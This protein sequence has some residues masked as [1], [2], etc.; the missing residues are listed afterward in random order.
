VSTTAISL[1][2]NVTL[3][4]GNDDYFIEQFDIE[5]HDEKSAK[6]L[7]RQIAGE[8]V[9]GRLH[10]AYVDFWDGR[11]LVQGFHFDRDELQWCPTCAQPGMKPS[12]KGSPRCES[13]SIASGG[14][15][16]HCTCDVCF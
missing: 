8:D 5:S 1:K 3:C 15:N 14:K 2:A 12:H 11:K 4:D 9:K 7:A 16:A 13:G 10:C 6:A